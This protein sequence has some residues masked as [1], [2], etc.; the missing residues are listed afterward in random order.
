MSS[1]VPFVRAQLLGCAT[2]FCLADVLKAIIAKAI[3]ARF[4]KDAHFQKL[5]DALTHVRHQF[6][7]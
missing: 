6:G 2:L 3:S 4:Q 1:N 5:R 7:I